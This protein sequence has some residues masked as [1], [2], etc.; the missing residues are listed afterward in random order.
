MRK[1]KAKKRPLLPDPR[2]NDQLV[3]RFV[4]NLMWSGKKST[5]FKIFYDAIDIVEEKNTD[6]EKT[7]LQLW[8]DALSNVMPHV[9]V[10]SRRV[11]GATFQIPMQIRADRKISTAMKWLINFARKRNEKSMALKLASE[12]L[13][14]SKEEGAAV[15]K[16]VDT[17]KMAEANKAF[18]HFRF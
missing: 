17:H 15:K 11:G 9:E 14:A 1:R 4:N 16:R 13:A 3:T 6:E 5:A 2:F 10:R 18:S 12:I 8:K 7:A